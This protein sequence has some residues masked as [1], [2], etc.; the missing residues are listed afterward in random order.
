MLA[1]RLHIDSRGHGP[2]LVLLHGWAMHSGIFA[3]LLPALQARFTVHAVDLPGHGRSIGSDLPLDFEAVW[4]QLLPRLDRPACILGWSLG[5]LFAL[6]G[7]SA[8]P[9]ACRALVMQNASPCFV[10]RDDWPH[11][12]PAQVFR[13]FAHDLQQDYPRTLQRFFMLE[14]QGAEHLRAELRVLQETAFAFGRPDPGV[15]CEGLRLLEQTDLRRQL[16]ALQV[17]SLWLAGR[18]DRLV[19]P[20]AMQAACALAA[21]EYDCDEHGG[22]AP[23]LSHPQAVLRAVS[24]FTERLDARA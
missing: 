5:G 24:R 9:S 4:Q 7:A 12:M 8:H 10:H 1:M 13:Q 16:P 22:H 18:R 11:G 3:P 14:A 17:P 23:F 21:G 6:H 15:L 20:L 19:S 2:A